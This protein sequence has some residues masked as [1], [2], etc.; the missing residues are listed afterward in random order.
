MC[1]SQ[2]GLYAFAVCVFCYIHHSPDMGLAFVPAL[3]WLKKGS[4]G[5][6]EFLSHG[7][8]GLYISVSMFFV[9]ITSQVPTTS[10]SQDV[11]T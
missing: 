6:H 5:R 4:M 8:F 9:P 11:A 3:G 1:A 10:V 2:N 7:V